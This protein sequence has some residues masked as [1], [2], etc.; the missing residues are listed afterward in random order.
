MVF[1]TV[2]DLKESYARLLRDQGKGV[3]LD[4]PIGDQGATID[5]LTDSEI[6]VCKLDLDSKSAMEAKSQLDFYGRFSPQWKKV[7]AVGTIWNE[8]AVTRLAD[9]GIEV[10]KVP[11]PPLGRLVEPPPVESPRFTYSSAYD[12][13]SFE[14]GKGS[15]VALCVI[16][17]VFLFGLAGFIASRQKQ[18]DDSSVLFDAQ[19]LLATQS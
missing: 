9:S 14:G 7:V 15:V 4:T 6:V 1:R 11:S 3:S 12:Y 19:F 13:K 5:I 2:K 17:L 10:V 18:S 8:Q 16:A